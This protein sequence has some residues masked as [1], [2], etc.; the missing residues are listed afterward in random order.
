MDFGECNMIGDK[1]KV[2][3]IF[4]IPVIILSPLYSHEMQCFFVS[5]VMQSLMIFIFWI[6]FLL[7][8]YF[9]AI[10]TSST[11]FIKIVGLWSKLTFYF[12]VFLVVISFLSTMDNTTPKLEKLLNHVQKQIHTYYVKNKTYPETYRSLLERSGCLIRDD[13][14]MYEDERLNVNIKE[15]ENTIFID[16]NKRDRKLDVNIATCSVAMKK[17]DNKIQEV[18]CSERSCIQLS[19]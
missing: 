4:I 3:L 2:F 6:P 10:L 5:I 8:C 12:F 11:S 14:C 17:T 16:I 7:V 1:V 9:V 15:T 19:H 13:E 18:H